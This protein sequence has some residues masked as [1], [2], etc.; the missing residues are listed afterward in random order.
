[1][2]VFNT[3]SPDEPLLSFSIHERCQTLSG[4]DGR[5]VISDREPGKLCYGYHVDHILCCGF[6]IG[7]R[8]SS[9]RARLN[10]I[11]AYDL[12]K[13]PGSHAAI[14]PQSCPND[15]L[16]DYNFHNS[17]SAVVAVQDV[18]YKPYLYAECDH[19]VC[20]NATAR[21][22]YTVLTNCEVFSLLWH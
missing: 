10:T 14:H 2:S 3:T 5:S 17:I 7:V 21:C 18:L 15:A 11:R 19:R 8:R 16:L 22:A 13:L 4:Q 12:L 9:R 20:R 6:Y 1:M